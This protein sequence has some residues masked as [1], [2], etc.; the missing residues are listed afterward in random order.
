MFRFH[1]WLKNLGRGGSPHEKEAIC[2]W[3]FLLLDMTRDVLRRPWRLLQIL[4]AC[5]QSRDTLL[6]SFLSGSDSRESVCNAGDHGSIP[7][8]GRSPKESHGN[9]LQYSCLE[10]P[11]D[12]GARWAIVYGVTKSQM[13]LKQLST[14][15]HTLIT[16]VSLLPGSHIIQNKN[17]EWVKIV[18]PI[19]SCLRTINLDVS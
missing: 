14:Q 10:N 5:K 2:H 1:Q 13:Q 19:M 11:M 8:L 3:L 17:P 12:R 18:P 4:L 15:A 7:G 9:P 6:T 16:E